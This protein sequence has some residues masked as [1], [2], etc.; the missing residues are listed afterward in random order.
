MVDVFQLSLPRDI[1]AI[2]GMDMD[3]EYAFQF[4][5]QFTGRNVGERSNGSRICFRCKTATIFAKV[6]L[7]RYRLIQ[8]YSLKQKFDY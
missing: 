6:C 3:P 5:R 2:Q 7:I 8:K 4:L 1:L